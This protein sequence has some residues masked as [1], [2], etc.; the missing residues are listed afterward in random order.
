MP[1]DFHIHSTASDGTFTPTQILK[2]AKS[3]RLTSI[4]IT[5]HDSVDG[6]AEELEQS[7]KFGIHA[8]PG[9]E[10]SS[11][12]DNSQD[13]HMLGYFIDWKSNELKKHLKNL[14]E[15]RVN[16]A[17]KIVDCLNSHG[18]R[19]SFQEVLEV[20]G[21]LNSSIG[22]GH[23]ATVLTRKGYVGDIKE[24]FEKLLKRGATCFVEKYR[25]RPEEVLKRIINLGGVPV[26]AHPGHVSVDL[27]ESL[28]EKGLRGIEAFHPDHKPEQ[29]QFFRNFAEK[30]GLIIT[31]G[32]DCHGPHS[33]RGLRMGSIILSDSYTRKL[34]KERNKML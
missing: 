21:G 12:S 32:S 18:Y 5:D 14:R 17:K 26:I 29:V 13:V 31:G 28:I 23:I 25:V 6:I 11:V 19:L 16:R 20:A 34:L 33:A 2:T 1:A 22:R 15:M 27:I 10:L 8:I 24:A 4:S 9:I 7:K 30:R 3:L